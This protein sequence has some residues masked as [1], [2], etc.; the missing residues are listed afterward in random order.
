[1]PDSSVSEGRSRGGITVAFQ[2]EP[3][4]YS[5]SA[6]LEMY[7]AEI[8]TE[9]CRTF[10]DVFRCVEL[11]ET[12][13]GLVPIENSLAGS[14]HKN[15][16]LLLQRDLNIVGEYHLRVKHCLMTLPGVTLGEVREVYSHPQALAQCEGYLN[17]RPWMECIPFA[18]TA[19]SAK[20]I[21][22]L[23]LSNVAAIASRR[24]A[25]VYGMQIQE[26]GIEDDQANYTRFL[27]LAR[28][29]MRPMGDSKT[30]IVFSLKHQP[31]ALYEALGTFAGRSI[32]L[33]K[34]ESRPYVGRPWQYLFYLDFAGATG[35]SEVK[36]ALSELREI[37]GFLRVLGSYMSHDWRIEDQGDPRTSGG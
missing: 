15:Y 6:A 32:D 12:H 25:E 35:Q 21:R 10:A 29:P 36:E 8:T 7:T 30:S 16:D 26:E 24:A 18:D 4:A 9:P 33:K 22:D 37:A 13:I 3:G 1:M 28:E 31:G 34:I 11:G 17:K 14:I 2:G 23:G 20:R 5:E 19:G 27:A